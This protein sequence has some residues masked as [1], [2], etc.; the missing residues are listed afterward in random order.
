MIDYPENPTPFLD[1]LSGSP[2]SIFS[3]KDTSS[4]VSPAFPPAFSTGLLHQ[5]ARTSTL[6]QSPCHNTPRIRLGFPG[7]AEAPLVVPREN[8]FSVP[9]RLR[10]MGR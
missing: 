3:T 1:K 2:S 5:L 10:M 9:I 8:S 6:A 4:Q 7:G